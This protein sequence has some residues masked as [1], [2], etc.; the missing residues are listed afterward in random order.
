M[1]PNAL[2]AIVP[3]IPDRLEQ[4][5]TF[6]TDLGNNVGNNPSIDFTFSPAT[7]FAR[8]VIFEASD[9]IPARLY[10]STCYDGDADTYFQELSSNLGV[11]ME[12]VWTCC[13][14]YAPGVAAHPKQFAKYLEPFTYK[15]DTFLIAFPDLTAKEIVAGAALR[16]T[17]EDL[18]DTIPA[19][20]TFPL[21]D[22]SQNLNPKSSPPGTPT[23]QWVWRIVD[24][25]VGVDPS[26]PVQSTVLN[27]SS[28]LIDMEDR[29][30][31][32]QMT[33][34]SAVKKGIW[35]RLM[36]R[37][38]LWIGNKAKATPDGKLSGLTTIHFARWVVIDNGDNLLFES[39]YDGS[40]ER[41]I[42]DFGDN[43]V[44]GMNSVWGNCIGFPKKGCLDIEAFKQV[45]RSHQIQAQF[46]YSA[47][48]NS[49]IQ[50]INSNR[51]LKTSLSQLDEY[52]AGVYE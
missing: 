3:I 8:W 16:E 2:T 9:G 33:I 50:N 28:D 13:E 35:P 22:S 41:Y 10:F 4:L 15:V 14:A 44:G 7:H 32:N 17:F 52:L 23:P 30:V 6:L 37:F 34:I 43:A 39:N 25:L 47:Y 46:F 38:M 20:Q 42:D 51:T 49:S 21:D 18:L 27:T 45:I 5:R 26:A 24:F 48:P 11:G 1:Q 31:Q 12:A 19:P 36:L 40:W 29:V